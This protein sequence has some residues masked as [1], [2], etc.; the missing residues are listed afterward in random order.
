MNDA[1]IGL[2]A[3][4]MV[5]SGKCPK[6]IEQRVEKRNKQGQL[7]LRVD[8]TKQRDTY[9]VTIVLPSIIRP[10]N[11][12]GFSLLDS[13]KL[14]Y[15]ID[16]VKQD[17]QE[18]LGTNNLEQLIVKKLEINANKS[19]P[20]RVN[21]DAITE[22][23]ARA[24][25]K[26][27][28]QQIEHCHGVN[29]H[30]AR[31]IKTKVID[32]FKTARDST[33]RYQCK[34]Y[35]KDRQLDLENKIN[36]TI[37]MEL[38]YNA[39][40]VS[41]ALGKKG[42]GISVL[43]DILQQSAMQKLILRYD[44]IMLRKQMKEQVQELKQTL[45]T[46]REE[47]AKKQDSLKKERYSESID[48]LTQVNAEA[49]K[50]LLELLLQLSKDN[51]KNKVIISDMMKRQDRAT[52]IAIIKLSQMPVYEGL[53]TPRMK[54]NLLVLSKSDAEIKWQEKQDSRAVEVG[55]ELADV[56]MKRFMLDKAETVI[57]PKENVMFD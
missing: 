26:P 43:T 53:I 22:L 41:Q 49:D 34:F 33:G 17:L 16:V 51:V 25:L 18:I 55:K 30:E 21:A 23:M 37:R 42:K 7:Y 20:S 9:N 28:A 13:V 47:I 19:V 32:G 36:P 50:I 5:V 3:V 4:T 11:I 12:R 10:T 14:E 35:R 52:S 8:K 56:T 54:E 39:K 57:F 44:L 1:V 29:I 2:D 15:V 46:K 45:T 40:G 38:V 27:D 31:T 6:Q 24:L 48:T